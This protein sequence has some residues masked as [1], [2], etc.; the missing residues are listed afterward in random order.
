MDHSHHRSVLKV[1]FSVHTTVYFQSGYTYLYYS[2]FSHN[3][4]D[5]DIDD[6]RDSLNVSV[7]YLELFHCVRFNPT[8]LNSSHRCGSYRRVRL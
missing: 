6:I 5:V 3:H 1:R 2:V 7:F 4:P 8:C